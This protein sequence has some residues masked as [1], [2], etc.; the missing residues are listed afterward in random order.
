MF[1]GIYLENFQGF[2]GGQYIPL[3]PLTLI[4]GPNSS[5]KS[6]VLRALRLVQQSLTQEVNNNSIKFLGSGGHVDL[7][8]FKTLVHRHDDSRTVKIGVA[9]SRDENDSGLDKIL[10]SLSEGF[11]CK[12]I[13]FEGTYCIDGRDPEH[14]VLTFEQT[15]TGSSFKG[16]NLDSESQS[17]LDDVSRMWLKANERLFAFNPPG[18]KR[19]KAK[20]AAN[21]DSQIEQVLDMVRETPWSLRGFM[22]RRP[23]DPTKLISR[24]KTSETGLFPLWIVAMRLSESGPESMFFDES[25]K[26]IRRLSK[27]NIPFIGPLRT[28]P[29][30][31]TFVNGN[32]RSQEADARDLAPALAEN[33]KVRKVIS[34]W[35]FNTTNGQYRLQFKN[36]NSPSLKAFGRAGAL[37]LEDVKTD[38]PVAFADA[39]TGLSQIL[40][41]LEKLALS[42]KNH[43]S[44]SETLS[45]QV[46]LIEQPELHLHPRMQAELAS[47]FVSH[48]KDAESQQ[49]I[50]ETHSE[51]ML[52][53]LQAEI[54]RGNFDPSDVS[55]V[56]VD[57]NEESGESQVTVIP[58]GSDGS[59]LKAWP[60]SFS[61][62]RLSEIR[63]TR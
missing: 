61:E 11:A 52:L 28:V 2:G 54:Q 22:P 14:I 47:L 36:F 23:F 35:L 53:R 9:L 42:S 10:F 56:Y 5:G 50:A 16:W 4:F 26:L 29:E 12:S 40:P 58:V 39:G 21:V 45:S 48:L 27:E 34:S 15:E 38:T 13:T 32:T 41:I 8:T 19:A 43:A 33:T 44:K 18:G 63:G 1:K 20:P 7:G 6:S 60:E 37:V 24:S 46:I 59:F 57:K 17:N 55:L 49:V 30:R 62:L 3:R 25:K 51:A 31:I